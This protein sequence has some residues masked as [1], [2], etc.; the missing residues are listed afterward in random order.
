LALNVREKLPMTVVKEVCEEIVR[1]RED[2][3]F[4]LELLERM[5]N[6]I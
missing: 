6:K 4:A 1:V 2:K 3:S 5:K